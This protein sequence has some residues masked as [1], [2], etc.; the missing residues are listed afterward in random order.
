MVHEL[1][2]YL[3]EQV[4]GVA[5]HVGCA[6]GHGSLGRIIQDKFSEY[7]LV[8]D[9]VERLAVLGKVG[10]GGRWI[11][12]L[13]NVV[14][15]ALV[16]VVGSCFCHLGNSLAEVGRVLGVDAAVVHFDDRNLKPQ[17]LRAKFVGLR[18]ETK[19]VIKNATALLQILFFNL[20]VLGRILSLVG[21]RGER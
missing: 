21:W 8:G 12:R 1:E 17:K 15:V 14:V 9:V 7:F 19:M 3:I 11:G 6:K 10:L 18:A 13:R 4:I 5:V 20:P 16:A 2:N